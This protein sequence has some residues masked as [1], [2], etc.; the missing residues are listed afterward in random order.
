MS[1]QL[2]RQS[3]DKQNKRSNFA[4]IPEG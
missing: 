3:F 1:A 2:K 4:V